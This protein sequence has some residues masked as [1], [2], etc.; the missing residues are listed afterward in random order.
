MTP[1]TLTNDYKRTL[2]VIGRFNTDP[3]TPALV[4]DSSDPDAAN[5]SA[6]DVWEAL[7]PELGQTEGDDDLS[8]GGF[9]YAQI[10][11]SP[12]VAGEESS[13]RPVPLDSMLLEQASSPGKTQQ[14]IGGELVAALLRDLDVVARFAG[15]RF[16]NALL[17]VARCYLVVDARPKSRNH[18]IG[19]RQINR[20][21]ANPV[22]ADA[23]L[24][25]LTAYE[26]DLSRAERELRLALSN[27][28]PGESKSPLKAKGSVKEMVDAIVVSLRKLRLEILGAGSEPDD[29]SWRV[30]MGIDPPDEATADRMAWVNEMNS[31]GEYGFEIGTVAGVHC[32]GTLL[33]YY[34]LYM[35]HS[36]NLHRFV[37][38]P[39]LHSHVFLWLMSKYSP[40]LGD[41]TEAAATMAYRMGVE[42][43]GDERIFG[44]SE[45]KVKERRKGVFRGSD[46]F[47]KSKRDEPDLKPEEREFLKKLRDYQE[48]L[49][50]AV[51]SHV[52]RD[53]RRFTREELLEMLEILFAEAVDVTSGK[54]SDILR[55]TIEFGTK[56][57]SLYQALLGILESETE[58][59]EK[60]TEIRK[61]AE[62]EEQ[63][64]RKVALASVADRLEEVAKTADD[65]EE[66]REG[67]L[68]TFSR[69]V[70]H[71]VTKKFIEESLDS[72]TE[73]ESSTQANRDLYFLASIL[74]GRMGKVR[75]QS[76]ESVLA[77]MSTDSE[78]IKRTKDAVKKQV[79]FN[80]TSAARSAASVT[81]PLSEGLK[82]A[83][84]EE[85]RG[86]EIGIRVKPGR[87]MEE[88]AA[89]GAKPEKK[90]GT[91]N[92][93]SSEQRIDVDEGIVYELAEGDPPELEYVVS[94]ADDGDTD[95]AGGGGD[96]D[97]EGEEVKVSDADMEGALG[98]VR[99]ILEDGKKRYARTRKIHDRVG[100]LSK[101]AELREQL[102]LIS[103][104]LDAADLNEVV[105]ATVQRRLF[106]LTFGEIIAASPDSESFLGK[107]DISQ[108]LA[109][110]LEI[111]KELGDRTNKN[112]ADAKPDDE[113][114]K[115]LGPR[116]KGG[117]RPK[118]NLSRFFRVP[119]DEEEGREVIQNAMDYHQYLCESVR[120]VVNQLEDMRDLRAIADGMSSD[121]RLVIINRT[122]DEYANEVELS[123]RD[124]HFSFGHHP[125][126]VYFPKCA[127]VRNIADS[128]PSQPRE[129]KTA[130]DL[131]KDTFADR[132]FETI[133]D[134]PM[135][136]PSC[137]LIVTADQEEEVLRTCPFPAMRLG[138]LGAIGF[139]ARPGRGAI[140]TESAGGSSIHGRIEFDTNGLIV[141]GS[142]YFLSMPAAMTLAVFAENDG[143]LGRLSDDI[144]RASFMKRFE[145]ISGVKFR[146]KERVLPLLRRFWM[147]GKH[148]EGC[149]SE[150]ILARLSS[151]MLQWMGETGYR[152]DES[153]KNKPFIHEVLADSRLA[154]PG[155]TVV[156]DDPAIGT[157][158]REFLAASFWPAVPFT[159]IAFFND[160]GC[161]NDISKQGAN[162][163]IFGL[164]CESTVKCVLANVGGSKKRE[165]ELLHD[166]R[167]KL[168]FLYE[169]VQSTRN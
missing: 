49:N 25:V 158:Q 146:E 147:D 112:L 150:F 132:R 103:A 16:P 86:L 69:Q 74:G 75:D 136:V 91:V 11:L 24:R 167:Q 93:S 32:G 18:R 26:A 154:A 81:L 87:A 5:L 38:S 128:D 34:N 134:E 97:A 58:S 67:G 153:N 145:K 8:C 57:Q 23:M 124:W 43:A 95:A 51:F 50:E 92:I 119:N 12:P 102:R 77:S 42:G 7:K 99:R 54:L 68:E 120:G 83:V 160:K 78:R 114:D 66:F 61:L 148:G 142:R 10:G 111:V 85:R 1:P 162:C 161:K 3:A 166:S 135:M 122:F 40:I 13:A 110:M 139:R 71:S 76:A 164:K 82:A 144:A 63:E 163:R 149:L 19:Q 46:D 4:F 30:I 73:L 107:Q 36:G 55:D 140:E 109:L 127:D 141:E 59:A 21:V 143:V 84:D 22:Y 137:P 117:P 44:E 2:A 88:D 45:E 27:G 72:R 35:E 131:L 104:G 151:L 156:N 33:D 152:Q 14:A 105:R 116:E 121:T 159:N 6:A 125:S 118:L 96:G 129:G 165:V 37:R 48:M 115:A 29:K 126:V 62:R 9:A 15:Y 123:V 65:G 101:Y 90:V 41:D 89:Q 113:S 39:I 60:I 100:E 155:E 138:S 53:A 98:E 28:A 20:L 52:F 64:G 70:G 108:T 31:L 80:A 106:A 133:E 17:E 79:E 47:L 94:S 56:Y 168:G 157:A 130:W 169:Q